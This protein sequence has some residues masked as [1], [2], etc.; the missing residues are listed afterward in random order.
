MSTPSAL[1]RLYREWRELADRR[2]ADGRLRPDAGEVARFA[3][4][5]Q[6]LDDAPEDVRLAWDQRQ[7]EIERNL[8]RCACGHPM[9][10]HDASGRCFHV[11]GCATVCDCART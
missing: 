3:A 6:E 5:L 11:V 10:H 4:F 2:S 9:P 7:S 8:P 1:E